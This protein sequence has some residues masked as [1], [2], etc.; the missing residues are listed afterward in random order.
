MSTDPNEPINPTKV[1]YPKGQYRDSQKYD[2]IGLT[3]REHFAAI[4]MQGIISN[5]EFFRTQTE[6][7]IHVMAVRMAD[8]LITQL[9]KPQ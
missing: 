5:S 4:A 3:K 7:D 1:N 8:H 6:A 2:C 9:N